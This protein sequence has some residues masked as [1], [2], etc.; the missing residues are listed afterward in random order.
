MLPL[1]RQN[2][3]SSVHPLAHV[4]PA[5]GSE[6][7]LQGGHLLRL[8]VE[9][10]D[11]QH[12]ALWRCKTFAHRLPEWRTEST[13]VLVCKVLD[14]DVIWNLVLLTEI[15]ASVHYP[16]GVCIQHTQPPV[17]TA[18]VGAM[19]K[20]LWHKVSTGCLCHIHVSF[21]CSHMQ[22]RVECAVFTPTCEEQLPSNGAASEPKHEHAPTRIAR[23]LRNQSLSCHAGHCPGIVRG[24]SH[25]Y[26]PLRLN[27]PRFLSSL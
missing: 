22:V 19:L 2:L 25:S 16:N 23:L 11:Q 5:R 21:D 4:L 13:W 26:I 1:P 24:A 20:H 10:I 6:I 12:T 14:D 18:L 27:I 8:R 7:V 3:Q 17:Q 15:N 9:R